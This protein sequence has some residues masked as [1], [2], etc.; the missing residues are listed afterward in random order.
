MITHERLREALDYAP[1]TG[2]FTWRIDANNNNVRKGDQAGCLVDGYRRIKID[3]TAYGAHRLAF[4][5]MK[6]HWPKDEIDHVDT[7]GS[8]DNNA[9]ENLR[10]AT[11]A[12]NGKNLRLYKN[13]N[14]GIKGVGWNK[15]N[16]KWRARITV[17][18]STILLGYF[19]D[20]DAAINARKEAEQKYFGEFCPK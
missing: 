8:K 1:D 17:D 14:S 3:G 2:I 11:H 4:F 20:L 7:N 18:S 19:D 10:E 6:G 5:Y 15:K 13:N 16:S 12:Q 9:W